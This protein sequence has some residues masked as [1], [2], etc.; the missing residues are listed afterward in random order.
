[1]PGY[2]VQG[3]DEGTGLLP[4]SWAEKRLAASHDFWLATVRPDGRPHLMP[5]WAV[6]HRSSV[7]FSCSGRSRKTANLSANARCSISTDNPIEPVV[8]EGVAELISNVDTLRVI[9]DIENRKYSTNYTMDLFDPVVNA[10]FRI[11]PVWT[12]RI[13]ESDFTGLPTRWTFE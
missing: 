11:E 5:V 4:W 10:C 12:F 8:I 3:P 1:M 7:W 9:L 13:A 6:W 2:G